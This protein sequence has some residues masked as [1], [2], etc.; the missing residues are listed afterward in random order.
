MPGTQSWLV[1]F[2]TDAAHRPVALRLRQSY[3][4]H[5]VSFKPGIAGVFGRE[6]F[7]PRTSPA[8]QALNDFLL[9]VEG[10]FNVL[11]LQSLTVRYEEATGQTL[12]YV[13]ACA[14]GGVTVADV[15]TIKRVTRHP[16]IC[17]DHDA[18]QAGFEL[19][20]SVQKVMPIEA[21]TTPLQWGTKS[22]LD[23]YIRDFQG[24]H[25][26]AWQGVKA[27]I[28]DRQPY[29]RTYAGTGEEFFDYPIKIWQRTTPIKVW[30]NAI[31]TGSLRACS[32]QDKCKLP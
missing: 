4:R 17:Y 7:T 5:F 27:L 26:A 8:N 3:T 12:G 11:Q 19:V 13:N 22:D 29:G 21:C 16:V 23:S 6:L 20:K 9:V 28:A 24:D 18:N 25:T 15:E 10:E 31:L 1:F 14:V 30:V 2:Y 32:P